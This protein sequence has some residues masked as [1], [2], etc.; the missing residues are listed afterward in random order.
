V[1]IYDKISIFSTFAQPFYINQEFRT[2]KRQNRIK[3]AF[4][5]KN[6]NYISDEK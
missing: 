5:Q 4:I 6:G 3:E 1:Q 2:S